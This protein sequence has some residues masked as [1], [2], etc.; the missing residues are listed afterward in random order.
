MPS[1]VLP[2]RKPS[3]VETAAFWAHRSHK[4]IFL[5]FRV[6]ILG[7]LQLKDSA[8]VI[9]MAFGWT[10][11]SGKNP[12]AK[13]PVLVSR[14]RRRPEHGG[15]VGPVH[16]IAGPDNG[17][18]VGTDVTEFGRL[19]IPVPEIGDTAVLGIREEKAHLGIA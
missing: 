14:A 10:G 13:P 7:L 4:S 2:K 19:W 5:E 16:G 17:Y 15:L 6:L 1:S 9:G 8:V 12:S 18:E 3:R 11:R